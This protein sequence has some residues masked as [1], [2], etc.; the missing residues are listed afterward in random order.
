MKYSRPR[1]VPSALRA[2]GSAALLL[3]AAGSV[4]ADEVHLQGG[5]VIEGRATR[6]GDS[7]A[8]R[9]ESGVIRLPADSIERIDKSE[10]SEDVAQKRRA[11]LGPRDIKGR[12][13]LAAYCREHDLRATERALL[14]EVIAL[15]PNHA[16]ARRLLGYVRTEH[17]WVERTAQ[18]QRARDAENE[19][20]L[21]RER[22]REHEQARAD[23]ERER[24]L[25]ARQM[26]LDA[27]RMRSERQQREAELRARD[28]AYYY[29][30]PYGYGYAYG[31]GYLPARRSVMRD[32]R[33]TEE[34]PPGG[35]AAA[36]PAP[37]PVSPIA[38][39]RHP[40]D[41]TWA[42]PGVKNPREWSR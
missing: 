33:A 41:T 17:G 30:A 29:N 23:A 26:Q 6:D 4:R 38:G 8:V 21:A 39:T 20:W 18:E 42:L 34:C 1:P 27:E 32:H 19:A 9:V 36:P 37:Q 3:L 11:A 28:E 2:S 14:E 35:C 25:T 10:T 16:E 24:E 5:S 12:L 40:R 13:Q 15:E 7:V 22:A 31:P